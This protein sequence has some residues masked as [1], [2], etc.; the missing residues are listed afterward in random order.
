MYRCT[1]STSDTNTFGGFGNNDF[2]ITRQASLSSF[3]VS[4][5]LFMLRFAF[6]GLETVTSQ[7]Y[8]R[9]PSLLPLFLSYFSCFASLGEERTEG[10]CKT[11]ER[12]T[13]NLAA[14]FLGSYGRF[15]PE[16]YQREA[17]AAEV[18][19]NKEED[20]TGKK[21]RVRVGLRSG[22]G[23]VDCD[24]G[25]VWLVPFAP[26]SVQQVV[27]KQKIVVLTVW[28]LDAATRC[29]FLKKQ[30]PRTGRR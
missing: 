20:Q 21:S 4:F 3:T 8:A 19:I 10:S 18:E 23:S 15:L 5:I 11:T 12:Q 14:S 13:H 1:S 17:H 6:G 27:D 26:T 28:C 30:T 2:T 22:R 25:K 7:L 16:S 9:P 29:L 24:G